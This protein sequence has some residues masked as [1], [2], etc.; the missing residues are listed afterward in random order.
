MKALSY[1]RLRVHQ[2]GQQ[3]RAEKMAVVTSGNGRRYG[4]IESAERARQRRT[5]LV[6]AA[7]ELFGTNGYHKT[8][9]KQICSQAGLTE[10]YFYESFLDR[11][12]ALAVV[13][14]ELIGHL[15]AATLD[16][17][18]KHED[19]AVAAGALAALVEYLTV[20]MR[21]ARIILIEVV[22]VSADLEARRHGVMHEFA[23]LVT[24]AWL[25]RDDSNPLRRLMSVALVGAVNHV[26]VDWLLCGR[27]HQPAELVQACV[28]LFVEAKDQ[29]GQ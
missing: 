2:S 8:T 14:E 7:V 20:D 23:E 29:L 11:E 28:A 13:Y 12:A 27:T 5:A 15:R 9:V 22:G 19:Q 26:L 4:G 6:D 21:R 3:G 16:A 18:E 24:D 17:I 1:V 25:G 10:R